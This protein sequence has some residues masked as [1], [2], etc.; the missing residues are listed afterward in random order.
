MITFFCKRAIII[1]PL[2]LRNLLP[3]DRK[4]FPRKKELHTGK[5]APQV[6]RRNYDHHHAT[7]DHRQASLRTKQADLRPDRN[8]KEHQTTCVRWQTDRRKTNHS[9]FQANRDK[10]DRVQYHEEEQGLNIEDS[11]DSLGVLVYFSYTNFIYQKNSRPISE[12]CLDHQTL[13]QQILSCGALRESLL[14][15]IVLGLG[16]TPINKEMT[17]SLRYVFGMNCKRD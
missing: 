1:K 8:G 10:Q 15:S 3:P 14:P 12:L 2:R 6:E 13:L 17:L 5:R 9:I 4:P 16:P 11:I 7:Q